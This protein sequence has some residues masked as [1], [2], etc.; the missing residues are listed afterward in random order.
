MDAD[1]GEA[2]A[3]TA[4]DVEDKG[5]VL[6]GRSQIG[7]LIGHLLEAPTVVSDGEVALGEG[8]ELD[9]E[10]ECACLAVPQEVSL[11]SDP[12]VTNRGV[13]AGDGLGEIIAEGGDDPGLDHVVHASQVQGIRGPGVK[14]NMVL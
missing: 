11:H 3:Q 13:A 7:E 4:K 9:V 1:V 8:M 5:A 14:Q 10:E 2:P 12:K 6:N